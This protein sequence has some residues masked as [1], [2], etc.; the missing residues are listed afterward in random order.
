MQQLEGN[1]LKCLRIIMEYQV[2]L[3]SLFTQL[4]LSIF[5]FS[6]H[7]L[8]LLLKMSLRKPIHWALPYGNHHQP[9]ER[10]RW[11]HQQELLSLGGIQHRYREKDWLQQRFLCCGKA[12]KGEMGHRLLM[13]VKIKERS[14]EEEMLYYGN[15][16]QRNKCM[17][18]L[19]QWSPGC[20]LE[21][22]WGR[23]QFRCCRL[24]SGR[25]R[26]ALSALF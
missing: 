26:W 15:E 23:A 16:E 2:I 9:R 3:I 19:V 7:V 5:F 25:W 18:N 21:L 1:T 20:P 12:E 22:Q 13:L 6:K 14:F 10:W 24:P 4:P 17:W 11:V 8:F